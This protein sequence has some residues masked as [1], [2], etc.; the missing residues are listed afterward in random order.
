MAVRDGRL[1]PARY[2]ASGSDAI[3]CIPKPSEMSRITT[4][5]PE[6]TLQ[7]VT[8]QRLHQEILSFLRRPFIDLNYFFIRLIIFQFLFSS[9]GTENKS[10]SSV[11]VTQEK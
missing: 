2:G 3:L 7:R 1:G 6:N 4:P 11:V 8:N 9:I 10:I 5:L